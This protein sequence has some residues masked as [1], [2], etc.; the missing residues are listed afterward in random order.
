[1]LVAGVELQRRVA[2]LVRPGALDDV[3]LRVEQPLPLGG[4]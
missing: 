2:G 4:G 1:V 3:E